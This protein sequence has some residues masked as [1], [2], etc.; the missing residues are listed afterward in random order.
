MPPKGKELSLRNKQSVKVN[1]NEN[2]KYTVLLQ[3]PSE[4]D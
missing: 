4:G 1:E 2:L 3:L